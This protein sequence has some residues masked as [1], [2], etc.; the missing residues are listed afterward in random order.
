MKE[1]LIS[2]TAIVVIST[3]LL[4]ILPEGK[5]NGLI[6]SVFGTLTLLTIISPIVDSN[7]FLSPIEFIFGEEEQTYQYEYLDYVNQ[8]KINSLKKDCKKIIEIYYSNQVEISIVYH[9]DNQFSLM[10]DKV[11]IDLTKSKI[12]EEYKVENVREIIINDIST[13]LS[14]DRNKIKINE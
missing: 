10:I 8:N 2:L 14:I 12:K 4:I 3:I 13:L 7:M 6:K 5:L 9:R 11:E 1:W